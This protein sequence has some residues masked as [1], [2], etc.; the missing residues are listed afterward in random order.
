MNEEEGI[1]GELD[2]LNV[3]TRCA[4]INKEGKRCR[5]RLRKNQYLF[6]CD[7]HRPINKDMIEDG[8]FCCSEKL[9]NHKDALIF[10]CKHMVH[11]E[12]YY[13]WLRVSGSEVT[14]CMMCRQPVLHTKSVSEDAQ[15][16]MI[17]ENGSSQHQ[18]FEKVT[19]VD[20]TPVNQR[21]INI[22]QMVIEQGMVKGSSVHKT[23]EELCYH[24]HIYDHGIPS[25]KSA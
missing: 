15:G 21:P 19:Y 3:K 16:N 1:F 6:C 11:K 10:R 23:F 18:H 14:I 12:C 25:P 4:G 7:E 22:I 13:E 5:T 24:P 2:R 17:T 20:T 9:V 8:C